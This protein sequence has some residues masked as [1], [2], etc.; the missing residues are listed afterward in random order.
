[1]KKA[2]G[3]SLGE[4]VFCLALLTLVLGGVLKLLPV[5]TLAIRRVECSFHAH[6]LA[7]SALERDRS[8]G[9]GNLVIGTA[10][11]VSTTLDNMTYDTVVEVFQVG[12]NDVKLIKGLRATV[13][14]Q[15]RGKTYQVVRESWMSAVKS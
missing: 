2:R 1:M 10:P 14:W 7:E 8:G 3:F 13:Q 12:T 15:Y 5:S 6:S 4:M 11:T 9:F